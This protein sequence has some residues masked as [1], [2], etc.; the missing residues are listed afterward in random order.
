MSFLQ[1]FPSEN[2]NVQKNVEHLVQQDPT[3][4]PVTAG[5]KIMIV[6]YLIGFSIPF[7]AGI[8]FTLLPLYRSLELW[9][10]DIFMS[11]IY[12]ILSLIGVFVLLMTFAGIVTL[13]HLQQLIITR[14]SIRYLGKIFFVSQTKT[15][16]K[17]ESFCTISVRQRH[18]GYATWYECALF[19]TLPKSKNIMIHNYTPI[20]NYTKINTTAAVFE[21]YGIPLHSPYIDSDDCYKVI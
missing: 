6:L 14:D 20:D 18:R 8:I 1:L 19:L 3:L 9:S 7:F 17:I 11:L 10:S 2:Q 12:L 15:Y 21:Q 4:N 16:S 13:V 5:N